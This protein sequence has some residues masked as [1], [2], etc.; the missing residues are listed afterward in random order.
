VS[1]DD[2]LLDQLRRIAGE[3]DPAPELVAESAR[4]AFS[5]RRLD[6]EL[7][8][9]LNDSDVAAS[10]VRGERSGPRLLSFESGPVSLELQIEDVRDR[11]VLRGVAVGTVG[12]AEVETTTTGPRAAAIDEMG[13][14][15][16]EGLPVEPLRVRVWSAAG[17]SVTTGWI[18][19]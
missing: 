19:G 11:L 16:I 6:D 8:E 5:T 14:F 13:W 15:R 18:R 4:A 9:L 1:A 12:A 7:A 10:A 3:V 2:E 17:T